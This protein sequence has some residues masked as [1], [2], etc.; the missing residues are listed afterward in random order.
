MAGQITVWR[1]ATSR[2]QRPG[3]GGYIAYCER[4]RAAISHTA[5]TL[6]PRMA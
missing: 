4:P 1:I 5:S 3:G 2:A 6:S